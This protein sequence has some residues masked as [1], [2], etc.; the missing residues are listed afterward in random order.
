MEE[1]Q[2]IANEITRSLPEGIELPSNFYLLFELALPGIIG[3]TDLEYFQLKTSS[4]NEMIPFFKFDDGGVLT[5]WYVESDLAIVYLGSEGQQEVVS[6]SFESF[7]QLLNT[8]NTGLSEFDD[9]ENIYN[10]PISDYQINSERKADLTKELLNW[11][12]AH[13]TLLEP[14][15]SDAAEKIRIKIIEIANNMLK[16]GLSKGYK[17]D[18]AWWSLS[19]KIEIRSNDLNITYRDYGKW[20]ELPDKYNLNKEA[21]KLLLL[22][23]NKDRKEYD[24]SVSSPGI[25]SINNDTELV[26]T[27]R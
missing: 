26:L 27:P 5:F 18:S 11:Y 20:Y 17:K 1:N 22:V 8:K 23:K 10:L 24:L 9:S 21:R 16:D 2:E 12:K 7:L 15:T 19:F 14:D 25:V 4:K 6:E 3:W 13:T